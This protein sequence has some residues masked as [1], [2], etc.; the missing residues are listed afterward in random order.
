MMHAPAKPAYPILEPADLANFDAFIMGIPTRF[1]NFPA[2]WKVCY[3]GFLVFIARS[4]VHVP[5][6]SFWDAT[7]QLWASGALAGKYASLFVS[8]GT[9][10]GGQEATALAAMSTLAHHG[11]LYV[12]LGY[13]RT[14]AQLANLSEIH[15]GELYTFSFVLE[16]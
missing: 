5:I 2:Q 12:P 6:Q 10:G 11:V 13:S 9:Q 15:G 3:Y 14:F 16:H 7:G 8:T 4:D 1:G